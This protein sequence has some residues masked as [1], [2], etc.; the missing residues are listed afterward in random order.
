MH[1]DGITTNKISSGISLV[2]LEPRV[3]EQNMLYTHN[4]VL[5][6]HKEEFNYVICREMDGIEAHEVE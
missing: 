5:F 4:G 3:E 1:M 6:S 2:A